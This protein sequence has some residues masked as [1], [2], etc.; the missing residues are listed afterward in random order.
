MD[1]ILTSRKVFVQKLSKIVGLVPMAKPETKNHGEDKPP[2]LE[3]P[4]AL[5]LL[6][7]ENIKGRYIALKS[8]NDREIV[9]VGFTRTLAYKRALRKGYRSSIVISND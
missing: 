8:A 7:D 1:D 9:A 6:Q 2:S 4:L 3:P 5:Y